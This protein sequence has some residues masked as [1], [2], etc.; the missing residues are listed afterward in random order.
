MVTGSAGLRLG[1]IILSLVLAGGFAAAAGAAVRGSGGDAMVARG[2]AVR[3]GLG[4][5]LWLAVTAGLAAAGVLRF[6]PFPPTMLV[7]VIATFVL[8]IALTRSE[9]G[10]RLA[11]GLPLALLVGFQ[12]FR[13]LVELLLHRAYREGL[14]PV[15]MSWEGANFDVV[16]GVSGALLGGVLAVRPLPRWVVM[17]WNLVGLGLL[18]N[19]V[20][21]AILSAPGPL[22]RFHNE[23][24]NVWITAFPWVWLPAVMVLAAFLGH[25]LLFRRLAAPADVRRG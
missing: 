8:A 15:Q 10:R 9:L 14:M 1:F 6:E 2:A 17:V 7:V 25:L 4:A 12:G 19:I 23:P 3:A 20:T 16:S 13:V 5:G 11:L 22:R 24:A 21:I 18:L